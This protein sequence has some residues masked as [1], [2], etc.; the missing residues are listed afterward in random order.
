MPILFDGAIHVHYRQFY[1]ESRGEDFFEE[2]EKAR[3][4]QS[5]GL[6]GA[7]VPGALFLTTGLHTGQVPLTVEAYDEPP[8]VG[9]DWE[10]V[11]EV[12]FR[13]DTQQVAL[14]EW[15]AE[16][17][18]PLRLAQID[19]RVRYC[20]SGMDAAAQQDTRMPDEPAIDRYL[21][22]FWPQPPAPDTVLRRA[23]EFAAYWHAQARTLPPPN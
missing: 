22:Q 18:W 8:P 10:E 9:A 20:A 1:V 3:G 23:G 5:N 11:V 6:C 12:S 17:S 13:P 21:L 2:L 14:V 4:G 16:A 7:A 15:A 19:Y